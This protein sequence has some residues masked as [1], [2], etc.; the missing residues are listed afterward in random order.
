MR[1]VF[2]GSP[3]F[4]IP[5]LKI[6]HESDHQI[7]AVITQPD[8]PK[9]RKRL[10][11]PTE[12]KKFASEHGLRILTPINLNDLN[13]TAQYKELEP[14]INIVVAYGRIMPGW[15]I[16]YPS[17]GTLNAHASLL[18]RW[19]GAAP[20]NRAIMA[21]DK[22]TGITIQHVV[23]ELDAGDIALQQATPITEDDNY[24]SVSQK[25]ADLAANL[26]LQALDLKKDGK[27]PKKKQDESAVTYAAKIVTEDRFVDFK[28]PAAEI[29][30]RIRGLAPKPAAFAVIDN[31]RL[32]IIKASI[33]EGKGEAGKVI[34]VIKTGIII[35]TSD[36]AVLVEEVQ[37]EGG[38]EMP[39][40]EYAKGRHI[41]ISPPLTGGD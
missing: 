7:L 31:R 3:R 28:M 36:K 33:A 15:I 6:L 24:G 8:K 34:R 38:K 25:L 11:S 16:D 17:G 20:I 26:L 14:D 22:E 2:F 27:L 30:N 32:K 9:G 12:V 39:A 23:E 10:I 19:R 40:F 1:V 13:F 18:P 5:S 37:P 21:G 41:K 35:G 4:A 29:V